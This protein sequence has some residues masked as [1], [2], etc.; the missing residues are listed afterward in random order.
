MLLSLPMKLFLGALGLA[1][2][3]QLIT[4]G[5][6]AALGVFILVGFGC[7]ILECLQGVIR[8]VSRLLD[9]NPR[10]EYHLYVPAPEKAAHRDPTAAPYDVRDVTGFPDIELTK[11][12]GK[13]RKR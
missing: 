8:A 13:W 7:W 2:L 11:I 4:N 9:G 3:W 12:N 10:I 1:M 6:L 5:P